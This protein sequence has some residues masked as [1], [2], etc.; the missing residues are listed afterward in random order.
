MQGGYKRARNDTPSLMHEY[1]TFPIQCGNCPKGYYGDGVLCK[2]RCIRL[3]CKIETE[4]CSAPDTCTRKKYIFVSCD[5][6]KDY[7]WK[8]TIIHT[9][10]EGILHVIAACISHGGCKNGG[11]CSPGGGC[12][13]K[14]GYKGKRCQLSGAMGSNQNVNDTMYKTNKGINAIKF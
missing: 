8:D 4:Y 1:M 2:P 3:R 7:V 9:I 10:T 14:H 5:F 13:C 6:S 12:K 11:R